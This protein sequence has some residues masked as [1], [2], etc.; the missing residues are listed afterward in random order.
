MQITWH[1]ETKHLSDVLKNEKIHS[2]LVSRD[3]VLVFQH[4]KNSKSEKK[5]HKINS[6]TKSFT[7]CLIGIAKD[8]GLIPELSI[9]I[10]EFFP[11]LRR[12][13]DSR[14]Q[15]IT[16]DHLLT[17]S[18]G[19]DWPEMTEWDGWPE[20]IHS[21]NWIRFVLER[22]LISEPGESMN[23]NS[24]CSQLLTA[25]L[26][27]VTNVSANEFADK[28]LFAHLQFNNYIWH[29]DPQGI[30]IGGFG[31]HL[32]V[33]DMLKF[34]QLYLNKGKWGKKRLISEEWISLTTR[35]E[36]LTYKKLGYYGRHWWVSETA[37]GE[38]FY[39]AL[40]MG[41]NYICVVPSK[42]IVIAIT[43]DTYGDALVPLDII[44]RI[45]SLEGC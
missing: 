29:D 41:G 4:F 22:P 31:I 45:L 14:K 39:Y 32:S 5:L 9:P 35:P 36:Y 10:I 1:E 17:M 23:Y 16:I 8:Q 12:S 33:Q 20:M 30:R 25:I 7:S 37:A 13:S 27:K 34:G 42:G 2:C 28:H 19:F 11:E 15:L 18:A 3:G 44:K 43:N 26:Q 21:P 24:G 6:C 38:P 40:G